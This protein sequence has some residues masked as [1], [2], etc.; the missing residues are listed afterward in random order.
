MLLFFCFRF[1]DT[2]KVG[3]VSNVWRLDEWRCLANG[4]SKSWLAN[5]S[6]TVWPRRVARQ[7]RIRVAFSALTIFYLR[8]SDF[9]LQNLPYENVKA[10]P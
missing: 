8:F 9:R 6:D 4:D 5:G 2:R 7:A 1:L 3:L 10:E